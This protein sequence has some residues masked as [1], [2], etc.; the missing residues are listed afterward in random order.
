MFPN[1][2]PHLTD[3]GD[4]IRDKCADLARGTGDRDRTGSG[5]SGNAL[6]HGHILLL[7]IFFPEMAFSPH[8]PGPELQRC[9]C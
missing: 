9:Q 1:A 3:E 7:G 5:A 6:H 2:L 8:S 4:Q